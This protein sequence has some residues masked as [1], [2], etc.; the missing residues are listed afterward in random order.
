MCPENTCCRKIQ[1]QGW[2]EHIHITQKLQHLGS[3]LRNTSHDIEIF[4][5][6]VRHRM[7]FDLWF[8]CPNNI[9]R[10]MEERL[11]IFLNEYE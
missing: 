10:Y 5:P 3:R 7:W 2:Q 11:M 1:S 9:A 8:V 6:G 4:V